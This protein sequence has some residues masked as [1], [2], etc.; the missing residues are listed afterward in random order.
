MKIIFI[1]FTSIILLFGCTSLSEEKKPVPASEPSLIKQP[2][3]EQQPKED[4]LP[5]EVQDQPTAVPSS[6]IT[7]SQDTYTQSPLSYPPLNQR[8]TDPVFGTKIRRITDKTSTGYG[9]HIYSQLQAFSP[10]NSHI[11][12]IEDEAYVVRKLDTLEQLDVDLSEINAPRW[13]PS[14]I[15]TLVFYDSNAD[16]TIR[17]EY[18]QVETG[19]RETVFTFPSNYARIRP[20]QSFDE[21]SYD[22][23]WMAGLASS[24]DDSQIIF[25]VDIKSGILG[26]QIPLASLYNSVCA[27]DPEWG[28]IEPDWIGVSP[29]GNYLVVQWERDGDARCSGLETFDIET[30]AFIGRVNDR[31][32]H[33]DLGVLT[34]G[35]EFFMTFELAHPDDSNRPTQGIH[36][37]PGPSTG[38][39]QAQYLQIMEWGNQEHIS[40][41]GPAGVC[42]VTAGSD[43]STPQTPFEGELFLQYT[44]GSTVRLTHHRSSSCGYWVQ[45]R[46]SISRDGKYVV[47]ASDWKRPG[48]GNSC[49]GEEDSLGHGDAY[50]VEL[51]K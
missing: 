7:G 1:L 42:L 49:E 25:A 27:P 3:Q 31:H 8:F 17:V 10:D 5:R 50:L 18:V 20:T 22:G 51:T 23:R 19:N 6:G 41:Q 36:L 48:Q 13:Q 44:N 35:T 14:R 4:P 33:G 12:L 2:T 24:S 30:G 11:L 40:C 47:F 28:I 39:A 46:A 45:P 43:E 32:A 37:L 29:L 16:D 21:V 38:F 9:T 15:N 34:N 26:A